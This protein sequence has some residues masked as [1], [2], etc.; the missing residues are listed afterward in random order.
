MAYDPSP[1]PVAPPVSRLVINGRFLTQPM[2][3]VQRVSLE[4]VR[5]I[6]GILAEGGFPDL[7]VTLAVPGG[8][9][10][11]PLDLKRIA[12]GTTGG[13]RGNLW[14]QLVLPLQAR[15]AA[16]LCLGNTAPLLSLT[17]GKRVGVM[18]HDQAYRLFPA[19]YSRAYRLWHRILDTMTVRHA[20]PLFTVS[21]TERDVLIS[22]YPQLRGRICV[23]PNGGWSGTVPGGSRARPSDFRGYGL[24][25]GALS[26]R[27]NMAG[28]VAVAV[29]MARLRGR[30]FVVVGPVTAQVE[31]LRSS[32]PEDVRGLIEFRGHVP[33]SAMPDLYRG[34]AYLLY[35]SFYEA[36]GLPPTEA[37]AFGCPVVTA[38]LPVLRERC[39]DAAIFC[40][41]HDHRAIISAVDWLLADQA[42]HT[43][44]AERGMARASL[45]TWRSQAF[46]ILHAVQAQAEFLRASHGDAPVVASKA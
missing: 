37:M 23:T 36:S 44:L 22:R 13:P 24:Y 33:D 27:K 45:F 3:G 31:A 40:D 46:Q 11:T 15:R 42:L 25:V 18:L 29:A 5:A 14:E 17:V 12:I 28:I 39:G 38:D 26:H 10:V 20:A 16:L 2:S 4:V 32:V 21:D 7:T 41:P 1:A 34:A 43:R 30:R 8:T 9:I 19:D 6:D 35:P